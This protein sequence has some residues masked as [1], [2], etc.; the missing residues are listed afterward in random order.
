MHP[1]PDL[2]LTVAHSHGLLD[3][4]AVSRD[5]WP[6][7]TLAV[8]DHD[9]LPVPEAVWWPETDEE[10]AA[11]FAAAAAHGK[12]LV[13]WGAGSG[14]CGAARG[15]DGAWTL[16]LKRFDEIGT[17]DAE[18]WTVEVG[19]GVN[20]QRLED[21]LAAA[22]WAMGHSPS[23]LGCSTVGGWLAARGAGQ[24]SSAYGVAEDIVVGVDGVAPGF[25]RFYAGVP[26]ARSGGEP[27]GEAAWDALIGSEGTLGVITRARL[28]VRP[29]PEARVLRGWRFP[30]VPS[31][32]EAMRQIMQGELW[33]V[34]LRLYDPVD[35]WIGGKTKPKKA[36]SDPGGHRGWLA[37]TLA[38]VEAR[39]P[40][41]V[42]HELALPLALPRLL[43]GVADLGASGCLLIVGWEGPRDVVR[44]ASAAARPILAARGTDLGPGPGERWFAS[45]HA[46][47][48]KLMPIVL[49]G[50]FVDTMEVAAPWSAIPALWQDVRDA[51]GAHALVMAH[52]SHGYPEGGTIYFSF[53]GKGTVDRYD[54]AWK[55][56]QATVLRHGASVSHHHGIGVLKRSAATASVG[57]AVGAWR[58]HAARFDPQGLLNPGVLFDPE[59]ED[60]GSAEVAVP[61]LPRSPWDD[62]LARVRP[63]DVPWRAVPS[64]RWA[65][66]RLPGPSRAARNA[67]ETGWIGVR[68]RYRGAEVV[69]GRGPRE[70][71]G[72]DLRRAVWADGEDAEATVGVVR[73]GAV[74]MAAF[75]VPTPWAAVRDLLRSGLRP[76]AMGVV[77]GELL[78]GFRGPAAAAFGALAAA[79]LG[80]PARVVPWRILPRFAGPMVPCDASDPDAVG[81]TEQHVWRAG[82]GSDA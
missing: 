71:V 70:A 9:P 52:F 56:A 80:V 65:W 72:P 36:T 43:R 61:P 27:L 48:Y 33:P 6:R 49:R 32:I 25:G 47:S 14:V 18:T 38:G 55:A 69:L 75:A 78:L 63:G 26:G 7:D 50:G 2:P 12:V 53:A 35:T 8:R 17:V 3:R 28:R 64:I 29:L 4:M 58:D 66:D 51:V 16:D 34:V 19:A 82:E 45:R 15:R 11:V 67:W 1:T 81:A 57:A 73:E 13:P 77:E 37:Q 31:A 40:D 42:R 39:R 60:G 21:A 54:A 41:L 22:G 44:E 46:V 62:G 5:L 30:D 10:V 68:A 20:G 79:R 74:W 24:F 76:G 23:S 59:P